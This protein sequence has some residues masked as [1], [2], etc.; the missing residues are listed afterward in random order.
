MTLLV[1]FFQT[2]MKLCVAF[3][4]SCSAKVS[5]NGAADSR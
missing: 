3:F 4:V 1:H 5:S 2:A